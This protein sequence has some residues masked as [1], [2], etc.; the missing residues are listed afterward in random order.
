MCPNFEFGCTQAQLAPAEFF[1]VFIDPAVSLANLV[2][3]A[4]PLV[5]FLGPW[6]NLD[7]PNFFCFGKL[8]TISFFHIFNISGF[9]Q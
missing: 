2:D 1:F 4:D 9:V 5:N 6:F 7:V 3:L 8:T